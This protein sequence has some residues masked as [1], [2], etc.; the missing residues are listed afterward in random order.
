VLTITHG[1]VAWPDGRAHA[2]DWTR[3]ARALHQERAVPRDSDTGAFLGLA[4]LMF[5]EVGLRP[6]DLL[7]PDL[8]EDAWPDAPP[9]AVGLA[10]QADLAGHALAE[11]AEVLGP[12]VLGRCHAI[13]YL[14]SSVDRAFFQSSVVRLAARHGLH[15]VPHWGLGQVQ[16]TSLAVALDVADSVLT[17]HDGG[18]LLIAAETWPMPM[19][20]AIGA[21]TVLC[22]GAVSLW[23]SGSS[24]ARGLR[25]AATES[26]AFDPFVSIEGRAITVDEAAMIEAAA[27]AVRRILC[28]AGLDPSDVD[29]CHS[30]MCPALDAAVC[31]RLGVAPVP[32]D[33]T[34]WACAAASLRQAAD[35][36][37]SPGVGRPMLLWNLSL[38]G[39]AGAV[40]L[41]HTGMGLA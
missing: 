13:L 29:M 2:A 27:A 6:R 38:A 19:P 34:G 23:V 37:A 26:L 5:G 17:D 22:D 3:T 18:V 28:G 9:V 40:L 16:G 24:D 32:R 8:L 15:R 21:S 35:L 31:R 14:T 11:L 7:E 39:G 36:L 12:T 4:E 10:S 30:D 41:H 1:S 20:R 33:W 25:V